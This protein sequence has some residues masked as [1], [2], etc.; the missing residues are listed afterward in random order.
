MAQAGV[1]TCH[2]ITKEGAFVPLEA[3]R[4]YK[5]RLVRVTIPANS[6]AVIRDQLV[7]A[8]VTAATLFPDLDGL[9]SHLELRYFHSHRA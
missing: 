2:K 9:A 1:F 5:K 3:N 8:G 4:N 7:A 6:Y